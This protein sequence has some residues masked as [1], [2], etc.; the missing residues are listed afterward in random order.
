MIDEPLLLGPAMSVLSPKR[1]AFVKAMFDNP[2]GS[3]T[4]WAK[5]A[6]YSDVKEG[7]KVRAHEAYHDQKVQAA[8]LE[9]GRTVFG[10]EGV[11]LAVSGLLAIARQPNHPAHAKALE[12]IANR[13]GFN[14][15]QQIEVVHR[16]LTGDALIERVA[17]LAEKL[18]IDKRKYL[19]TEV[20]HET[21]VIEHKADEI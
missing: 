18:G 8:I 13:T 2:S 14:E 21:K 7:A 12:L 11:V 10:T 1:R 3:R 19:G 9:Y 20:S 17:Q 4:D 15:K 6:G 5:A 16:D